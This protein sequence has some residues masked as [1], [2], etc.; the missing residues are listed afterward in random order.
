M[1]KAPVDVVS[2]LFR[3]CN[4]RVLIKPLSS[5]APADAP[6]VATDRRST[7][8]AVAVADVTDAEL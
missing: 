6:A 2:L 8:V 4:Q 1:R 5:N 7:V 3:C